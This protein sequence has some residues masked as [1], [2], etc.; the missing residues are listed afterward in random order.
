MMHRCLA[1]SALQP[2]LQPGNLMD[3][4]TQRDDD[5][6]PGRIE[7]STCY[8]VGNHGD[9]TGHRSSA[10]RTGSNPKR[11]CDV[12]TEGGARSRQPR[13]RPTGPRTLA[14]FA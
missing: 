10:R 9:A 1:T 13:D 5:P 7:R 12:K 11:R 3:A 2:I 14:R 8:G 4:R 6:A